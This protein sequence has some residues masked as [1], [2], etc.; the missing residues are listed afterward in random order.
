[1]TY[2]I[3]DQREETAPVAMHDAARPFVVIY[4]YDVVGYKGRREG[5][6]IVG[7]YATRKAAQQIIRRRR[8]GVSE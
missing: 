8:K 3:Y 4:T 7:R 1:M 5:L 6:E 2:R